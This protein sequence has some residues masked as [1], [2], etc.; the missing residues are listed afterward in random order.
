L[1]SCFVK[2]CPGLSYCYL[3]EV[4]DKYLPTKGTLAPPNHIDVNWITIDYRL[5]DCLLFSRSSFIKIISSHIY[6]SIFSQSSK[7]KIGLKKNQGI[8][9]HKSSIKTIFVKILLKVKII[10]VTHWRDDW[11]LTD[12]SISFFL[13][14]MLWNSLIGG[15]I[16]YS[17]ISCYYGKIPSFFYLVCLQQWMTE[18]I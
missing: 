8:S 15:V 2:K 1:F 6:S 16:S 13:S 18:E 9:F 3:N 4:F 11:W 7:F 12:F 17:F 14:T 10:T 5:L